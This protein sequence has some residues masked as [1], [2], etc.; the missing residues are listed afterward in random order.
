MLQKAQMPNQS[1]FMANG[2]VTV[3]TLKLTD[4]NFTAAKAP[5]PVSQLQK[6]S[7][8]YSLNS[9]RLYSFCSANW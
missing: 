6:H 5:K 4:Y 1:C 2:C 8:N 3:A 9:T 7:D